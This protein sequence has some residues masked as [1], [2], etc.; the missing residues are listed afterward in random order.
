MACYEYVTESEARKKETDGQRVAVLV[1][2]M[3]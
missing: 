2:D 1:C 3:H